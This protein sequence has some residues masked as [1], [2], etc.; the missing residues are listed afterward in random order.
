[1]TQQYLPRETRTMITLSIM[2]AAVM[3]QVDTTIAN[4][5]LPHMQGTTSASRDQI[6][7]VLTSYILAM[8]ITTPLTGWLADRYGRKRLLLVSVV[9][10]T[11]VSGLCGISVRLDELVVFRFLQGMFGASM[12]PIAQVILMDL[13]PPEERG[14]SMAIFGLGFILGPLIGPLL[15]GWLTENFSWHWVFLINLPVGVAA[16][17]GITTFLPET[18]DENPR[19]FDLFGFALLALGLGAFQMVLDRGQTL[20]WFHSTEISLEAGLAALGLFLFAVHTLTTRHPF[21][22]FAIFRDRNFAVS[23]L[24]GLDLGV[25]MFGTI[26]LLPPM[27]AGLYGEPIIDVGIAMAPRGA[28]TFCAT[29]VVGRL[30]GKVDIRYLLFFGLFGCGLSSLALSTLS[31]QSDTA[32]VMTSGFINGFAMSFVFV[33]MSTTAFATLPRRYYNEAS[34][35]GTLI[36]YMGS[37]AAISVVQVVTT[38]NEAKVQSRLTEGLTPDNPIWNWLR[39]DVDLGAAEGAA[40]AVGETARQALMVSYIDTFWMLGVLGIVA[41][42]LVFLMRRP[43]EG[44]AQPAPDDLPAHA[45]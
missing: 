42:P 33:P 29:L 45:E 17:A 34:T 5:A 39:P 7:W 28:G 20:D 41:A 23:T 16:F 3:N 19:P 25:I 22:R 9:G 26:S 8:A 11:V 13:N 43:K 32:M 4:V 10:F 21:V 12:I 36:R 44:L 38:R 14:R 27:L 37:A 2:A 35:V 40:R 24:V 31:L 30:I 15:G 18:R 1:M 6:T